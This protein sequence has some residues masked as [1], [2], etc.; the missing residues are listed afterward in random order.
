MSIK[1]QQQDLRSFLKSI[2]LEQYHKA[3]IEAGATDRDLPQLMQFNDEELNEFLSALNMLPFHTIRFKKAIKELNHNVIEDNNSTILSDV[4]LPSLQTYEFIVSNSVIYGKNKNRRPLTAYE[5]AINE[6]SLQIALENPFLLISK[7][8]GEL[9]D[10]AKKKLLDSGYRYKRGSSRSKFFDHH[11]EARQPNSSSQISTVI[12]RKRQENAQRTS[13]RRCAEIQDLQ[14][15]L[16][17]VV[18]TQKALFEKNKMTTTGHDR[19]TQLALEAELIQVEETKNQLS[20]E[21]SK[22]KSQERKHQWYK[23]RKSE[24]VQNSDG[25]S[26][27]AH[28]IYPPPLSSSSS[29]SSSLFSS[30]EEEPITLPPIYSLHNSNSNSIPNSTKESDIRSLSYSIISK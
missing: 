24:K 13:E 17:K 27:K 4:S 3:F 21:I 28:T 14:Q 9:F 23:R 8:R 26:G 7:K 30:Q 22:L 16:D 2:D 20:K 5:E 18:Q 6:A 29:S 19:L 11:T 15:Q 12:K 10:L 1:E 25:T